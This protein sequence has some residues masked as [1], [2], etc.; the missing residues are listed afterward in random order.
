MA[1]NLLMKK[2]GRNAYVL[3]KYPQNIEKKIDEILVYHQ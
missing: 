2:K 3:V 1:T